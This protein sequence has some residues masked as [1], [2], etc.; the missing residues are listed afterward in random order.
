MTTQEEKDMAMVLLNP[1]DLKF[2]QNQSDAIIFAA[3]AE[4]GRALEFVKNQT[5]E[6]ALAAVSSNGSALKF[7]VDKTNEIA[8]AAV[9]QYPRA[10]EHVENQTLKVCMAA[11][12]EDAYALQYIIDQTDDA[13]I[14]AVSR[15]GAALQYVKNQTQKICLIAV[16]QDGWA[17][18]HVQNQNLE[19]AIAAFSDDYRT[20]EC[21]KYQTHEIAL[22]AVSINANCLHLITNRTPEI[23][24]AAWN[25]KG[26]DLLNYAGE[27]GLTNVIEFLL[28]KN[29]PV[30]HTSKHYPLTAFQCS[31]ES[32]KT[33]VLLT[34]FN[35]GAD[36]HIKRTDTG[37]NSM[38]ELIYSFEHANKLQDI[39]ST[40]TKLL[41]IGVSPFEQD[42]K[43]NTAITFA[44]E[45]P[46]IMVVIK[47]FNLKNLIMSTISEP[48]AQKTKRN[49][50]F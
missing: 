40:I 23:I 48:V 33:D 43:G 14:A 20:I 15:N 26:N 32:C 37:R 28:N 8:L 35:H 22:A 3:I 46:E 19:I 1:F 18:K 21:I 38:S 30:D 6:I 24:D 5:N 36:I 12:S 9:M 42:I 31:I 50:Q 11:V 47:A 29:V 4:D 34:L 16:S 2:V 25:Q 39:I 10:L 17:L 13:A 49:S 45:I 27:R 41:E 7:V 44:E